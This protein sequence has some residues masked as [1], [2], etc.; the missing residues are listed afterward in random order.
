MI[1]NEVKYSDIR[2]GVDAKTRERTKAL[3]SILVGY[4][5][6]QLIF[7][8]RSGTVPGKWWVQKVR[9]LDLPELLKDTELSHYDIVKLALQ[10]DI[11]VT[12]NCPAHLYWGSAYR[13]EKLGAEEELK[14]V[15]PPEH[16]TVINTLACKHIDNTLFALPFNARQITKMLEQAGVFNKEAP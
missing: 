1:L 6:G 2:K 8:T 10:G 4:K 13:L 12:C 5:N 15:E 16:N 9:L 11:K 14:N 7:N 3:K